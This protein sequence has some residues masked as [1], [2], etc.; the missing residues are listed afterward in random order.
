[1]ATDT[2]PACLVAVPVLRRSGGRS[3]IAVILL[4]TAGFRNANNITDGFE[5]GTVKDPGSVWSF[6]AG[7]M[8]SRAA[9][10]SCRTSVT[11]KS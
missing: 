11:R 2:A 7:R 5:G 8:I 3:A 10:P 1:V 4:A 6:T 9:E